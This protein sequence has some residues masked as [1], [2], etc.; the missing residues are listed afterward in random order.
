[1]GDITEPPVKLINLE[2]CRKP[3]E[4]PV[5]KSRDAGMD[6]WRLSV[7]VRVCDA[8]NFVWETVLIG[9]K[10]FVEVPKFILPDG[11]KERYRIG[12]AHHCCIF[13][14]GT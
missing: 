13:Y 1:V 7:N 9:C 14:F 5:V 8:V 11:S 10:L 4:K 3:E 6:G 12:V 2:G